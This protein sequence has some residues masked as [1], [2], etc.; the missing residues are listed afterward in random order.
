MLKKEEKQKIFPIYPLSFSLGHRRTS[1]LQGLHIGV[2]T[3]NCGI[4]LRSRVHPPGYSPCIPPHK[5]PPFTPI[6]DLSP[7]LPD[8]QT[9]FFL[10]S[11]SLTQSTPSV[12]DLPNGSQ[13]NPPYIPF[14]QSYYSPFFQFNRIYEEHFHQSFHPIPFVTLHNSLISEFH[15]LFILLILN[16]P[17]VVHLHTPNPRPLFV[18]LYH[19]LNITQ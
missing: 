10:T 15:T 12:L 6:L 3:H 16:K 2:A 9:F 8:I 18:P 11:H 13:Y 19:C 1:T 5:P 4:S 17:I 14:Q 7:R